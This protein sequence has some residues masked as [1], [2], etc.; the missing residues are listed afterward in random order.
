MATQTTRHAPASSAPSASSHASFRKETQKESKNSS[1]SSVRPDSANDPGIWNFMTEL[2]RQQLAVATE[3]TS[4]MYRGREALRKVQQ[5][6]AHEASVRH[7]E[8][9]NKLFS[10]CQVADLLAIQT[11]LMRSN[12]LSLSNYWQQLAV[13][14]LQTQREMMLSMSHLLDSESSGGMKSA[15]DVFHAAIPPMATSMFAPNHSESNEPH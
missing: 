15:M 8:A 9:A 11:D 12:V 2:G 14:A 7:A 4:A 5:D 10:P 1:T 13:V 6:T 3:S